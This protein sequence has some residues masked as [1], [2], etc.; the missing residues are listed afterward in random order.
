MYAQIMFY[1]GW[2]EGNRSSGWSHHVFYVCYMS[3]SKS[4]KNKYFKHVTKTKILILNYIRIIY[5]YITF[6]I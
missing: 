6:I 5:N 3:I 1:K 2:T 4:Q